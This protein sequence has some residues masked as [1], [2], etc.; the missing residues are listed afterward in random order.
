MFPI[1][2]TPEEA[3][4]WDLCLDPAQKSPSVS[5]PEFILVP[6][7]LRALARHDFDM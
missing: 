6:S 4:S 3:T 2:F 1:P 5:V 7:I